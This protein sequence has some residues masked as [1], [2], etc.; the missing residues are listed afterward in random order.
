MP[1]RGFDREVVDKVTSYMTAQ[2]V[3]IMQGLL[4]SSIVKQSNGKLLV[5][6]SD[7]KSEEFDTVLAAVGRNAD[8][9]NLVL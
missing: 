4:P 7:G 1:L 6:Y 3:R 5:T 8:T 2:G 9:R